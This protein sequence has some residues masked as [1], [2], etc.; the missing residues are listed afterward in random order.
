[1]ALPMAPPAIRPSPAHS[2]FPCARQAQIDNPMAATTLK[3]VSA[4]RPNSVVCWN[5]PYETPWF[6][7]RI[8]LK[9]GVT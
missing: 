5:M 8:R 3:I 1:M 6:Q 2:H 7:T 9:N 4:Q